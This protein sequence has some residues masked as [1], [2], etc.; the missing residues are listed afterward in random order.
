[1]QIKKLFIIPFLFISSCAS[2]NT[3]E[4]A[5]FPSSNNAIRNGSLNNATILENTSVK[6]LARL[7]KGGNA[8]SLSL[9][10]EYSDKDAII[11]SASIKI[12]DKNAKFIDLKFSGKNET[13]MKAGEKITSDA[14]NIPVKDFELIEVKIFFKNAKIMDFH[15]DPK[16]LTE[17]STNGDF[18]KSENFPIK[19]TSRYRPFYSSINVLNDSATKTIIAFGDSITDADCKFEPTHCRWSDV[20]YDRL[21]KSNKSKYIVVNQGISGN[22]ITK[23]SI[24]KAAVKRFDR[25]ALNLPNVKY[26][27]LLEGVNDIGASGPTTANP[28]APL[29]TTAELI[30]GYENLISRAH[31]KGIKIYASPILP[32]R[33]ARYFSEDKEKIRQEVNQWIKTSNKFDGIIDFDQAIADKTDPSTIAKEFDTGDHLHPN[34]AGQRVMGETINLEIFNE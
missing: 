19:E 5:F 18:T 4:Q 33:G 31:S 16:N 34:S 3:N 32:F 13:I 21:S 11:G 28:N 20:L 15:N 30:A 17:I 25:D 2:I 7:T 8:L 27:I 29:I 9:S 26:I 10:N 24:G 23:D 12:L 14:I 6:F 22:Q 1:M